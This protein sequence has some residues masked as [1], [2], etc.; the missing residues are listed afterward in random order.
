MWQKQRQVYGALMLAAD[1]AVALLALPLAFF[2]RQVYPRVAPAALQDNFNPEL[3]PLHQYFLYF[4]ALLPAWVFLLLVTQR[5]LSLQ[6][7]D[8]FGQLRRIA[9]FSV[10][11]GLL[12]GALVF[13]FKL[14]I[15]RP[16]FVTF[17]L[18]TLAGMGGVRAV[19]A[20]EKRLRLKDHLVTRKVLIV[21]SN[22]KALEIGRH[23]ES[24][25]EI[26]YRVIGHI[27]ARGPRSATRP[28]LGT[29]GDLPRIIEENVVDEVIVVGVDRADLEYFDQVC[30]ICQE[31]GIRTRLVADFF[32]RSIAKISL[33]FLQGYPLLTFSP[34][35][36]HQWALM[37]KRLLDFGLALVLL[38]VL[39]PLM[40]LTALVIKLSSRGPVFYRQTRC[41]LYGRY[42]TLVKFRS[43]IDGAQDVL[44]EIRH[45]NEMDGPVFKMRNDPR[46]TPLGRLLRR[47][48][49]DELPQLFNVLRGE[50]SLVGPRAPLPEEVRAYRPSQRRRLS[51][52]PGLTCLWQ[53]SGRSEIDFQQW[54]GLDLQ[55]IDNWSLALDLK[56]LLKTLPVVLFGRGAR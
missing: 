14:N 10:A 21:G 37:T 12:A 43:M 9:R 1:T 27:D 15:S 45:L 42:F 23:L 8:L 44:W 56:I 6:A 53:V 35:P 36:D 18:A 46:V 40:L 41:G 20:W 32:P 52:K 54:M 51:V 55:Y 47:S 39:S 7:I 25:R 33:D 29:V 19:F 34:T 50:M 4:L 38:A 26:G 49:I 22:E 16:L 48:S 31:F 13:F 5:Y 3:F 2:L 30:L 24:H 17:L 11:A 28:V